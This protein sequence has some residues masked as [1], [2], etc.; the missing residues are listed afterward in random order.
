MTQIGEV[1]LWLALLVAAWG[2]TLAFVGGR[3][4]R[5]DLVLSAERSVYAVLGL[6]MVAS[7]AIIAAFLQGEFRYKYVAGYS[8]RELGV[9]YKITG[10]WAGQTGSL[11]FW[12][13]L[14]AFFSS[15]VVWQNR[16]R[17][18]EFMPYVT[19][20]LLTVLAFFTV[21]VVFASNPFE[22]MSFTPADGRGLNPQLQNYWM[23]IH[24][25]TLY[26][27]FTAFTVPFAFCVAALLSGRLDTRWITTT[28][29]WTLT[30]W[31][32][33]TCGILFGMMWAYVELGWG[34]Y[35]FWD[36]V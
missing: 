11:V 16:R 4:G 18:R 1:A 5:G 22:L 31:F 26:L 2:A 29:R 9:F 35:W 14:L 21:V 17:N 20:T 24:P 8:N 12:A 33:L 23:T 27:G 32:F 7:A 10:L 13:L 25:P 3:R 36:P 30:A 34:G 15:L 28:R 19:G 6:F